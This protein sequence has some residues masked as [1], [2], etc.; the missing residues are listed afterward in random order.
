MCDL[1]GE[2]DWA[3]L[4]ESRGQRSFKWK[5]EELKDLISL[6]IE[7]VVIGRTTPASP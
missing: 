7:V 4:A 5:V 3:K 2:N 6:T 1:K